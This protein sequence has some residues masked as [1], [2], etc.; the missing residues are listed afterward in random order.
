MSGYCVPSSDIASDVNN[1]IGDE[2]VVWKPISLTYVTYPTGDL[3]G[4]L[5]AWCSLFPIF[6]IISFL[7]LILFRRELHTMAF[8]GGLLL[9]EILNTALKYSI[10]ALRPCRSG[11]ATHL[12]TKYGMPSSH[13]QFMAFFSVYL[14]L[15]AYIRL[16]MHVSENFMDN[17]RKHFMSSASIVSAV[18]VFYSRVYL[19]YHTLEQVLWGAFVGLVAGVLWF[20]IVLYAI[21]PTFQHIVNTKLAEYFLIRDSS[22]IPDILWF[23]YTASRAESRKRIRRTVQKSQ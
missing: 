20:Y 4:K 18:L 6:I 17:I 7:T 10:K 3:L 21:S 8:F 2:S 16:K 14:T 12:Y 15:F 9:N 23:E 1:Y 5:L 13:A 11:E 19:R 22:N